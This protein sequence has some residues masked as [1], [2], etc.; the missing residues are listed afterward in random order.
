MTTGFLQ[1]VGDIP[2]PVLCSMEFVRSY[3][4]LGPHHEGKITKEIAEI[5]DRM[6]LDWFRREWC[7][8]LPAGLGE[9]P[10]QSDVGG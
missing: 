10:E 4:L 6:F 3:P 9:E 7:C 8:G 2:V 1:S 5:Q